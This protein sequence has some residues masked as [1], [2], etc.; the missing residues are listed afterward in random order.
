[1]ITSKQLYD[2][3]RLV[4]PC[5]CGCEDL[6]IWLH[7]ESLEGPDSL[8]ALEKIECPDCG[9]VVYGGDDEAIHDWNSRIYD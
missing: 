3:Q 7:N 1:M 5:E 9:N 6:I 4:Q 8:E 2:R